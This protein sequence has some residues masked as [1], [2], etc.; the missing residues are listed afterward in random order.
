MDILTGC[1]IWMTFGNLA[2]WVTKRGKAFF[3]LDLYYFI[4]E[5]DDR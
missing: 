5:L 4:L 1:L 2:K 3:A